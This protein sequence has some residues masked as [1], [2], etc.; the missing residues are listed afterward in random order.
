MT[1]ADADRMT[2]CIA[3]LGVLLAVLAGVGMGLRAGYSAAAGAALALGDFWVLKRIAARVVDGGVANRGAFMFLA[4]FK[5]GVLMLLIGALLRFELVA[6]LPF[7]LGLSSLMGGV[8]LGAFLTIL[9]G[10]S[11]VESER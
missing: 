9:A 7:L 11:A 10:P 2:A 4:F 8:L 1:R 6:P 5:F 3:A